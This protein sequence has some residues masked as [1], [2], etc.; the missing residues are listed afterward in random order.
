MQTVTLKRNIF[1]RI[2]GICATKQSSDED[3]W[4]F[5]DGKIVVDLARAPELA[6]QNGA[7]RLEGKNAPERVPLIQGDDGA[8]HAFRNSCTHAGRRLDAV[9]GAQQVQCCSVGKSTF[10]Y[11]GEKVSGSAKDNLETYMVTVEDSKLLITL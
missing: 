11:G 1:Q 9:P 7:I 10:D 8:Y 6:S 4:T 3:C 5:E 2:F